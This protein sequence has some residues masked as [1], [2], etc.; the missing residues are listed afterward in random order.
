MAMAT[1]GDSSTV[2]KALDELLRT[3]YMLTREKGEGWVTWKE[4]ARRQE[5]S[6]LLA[7][8]LSGYAQLPEAQGLFVPA[9]SGRLVRLTPE[10][11]RRAATA[12]IAAETETEEV[13][14]AVKQY[15]SRLWPQRLNIEYV[16]PVAKVGGRYVEAVGVNLDDLVIP[17][18]TP[19]TFRPEDGS[20]VRGRLVG[21][22]VDGS[23]LYV[24]FDSEVRTFQL[25]GVLLVD[26]AYLLHQLAVAIGELK[27]RP[28]LSAPLWEPLKHDRTIAHEDSVEVARM[29][30]ALGARWSRYLWG[31]PGSGKTYALGRLA[32]LLAQGRGNGRILL[33]APSNLAVDVAVEQFV[34]QAESNGLGGWLDQ[35]RILRYGYPRKGSILEREELLGPPEQATVSEQISQLSRKVRQAE[36]EEAPAAEL[37]TLRAELLGVQEELRTLVRQ[38]IKGCA[39]VA[40]T[41]TLAYMQSSPIHEV[42]W[43]TVLV[44]EVTM[45]PPAVCLYLSHLAARRLLL[46]GDPRQLGPVYEESG[47]ATEDDLNW[48]GRDIFDLSHI[49]TGEGASRRVSLDDQRLARITSQRRCGRGIW[50]QVEH[51]YPQ[52]A[53]N[54]DEVRL[55]RL[56]DLPPERRQSLAILDVAYS[57]ENDHPFRSM[58]IT[59]T[60]GC[61]S[62]FPEHDDQRNG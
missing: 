57:G 50:V 58:A 56:R 52:V 25:P 23:T 13:A 21:Q 59:Q 20:S 28:P 4:V 1:Y 27:E 14:R 24:A 44:D 49:S 19:V 43:D 62:R 9:N 26:R 34:E 48:M 29:L 15:A 32:L 18:D 47:Q 38:H 60:G 12:Q 6:D 53:V 55:Q 17:S 33:T 5:G 51:L 40:T 2:E 37:A 30:A 11:K 10:G 22:E 36:R 41:T 8:E 45:V 54:V 61:R 42:A 31:P 3:I 35:R 7:T 39:L 46:A 16:Q